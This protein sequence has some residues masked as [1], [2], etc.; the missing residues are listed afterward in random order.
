[1]K[2]TKLFVTLLLVAGVMLGACTPTATPAP[3]TAP[4]VQPTNAPAP[5]PTTPP[6]APAAKTLKIVSS[7][8]LTGAS[9]TQTDTI[10]K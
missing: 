8:P 6:P 10:V 4:V 7:L 2:S 3:T 5:Q 1:M 9:L